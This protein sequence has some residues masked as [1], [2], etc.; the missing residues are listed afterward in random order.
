MKHIFTFHSPITYLVSLLTVKEERI[1]AEDAVFLGKNFNAGD[2]PYLYHPSFDG[3]KRSAMEKLKKPNEPAAFDKYISSIVGDEEYIAYVP[4]MDMYQRLLITHEKCVGFNFIE[5][6]MI[7][8]RL[9]TK[10]NHLYRNFKFSLRNNPKNNLREFMVSLNYILRGWTLRILEMPFTYEAYIHITGVHF[11]GISKEVF[12]LAPEER[13]T[14]LSINDTGQFAYLTKGIRLN[15]DSIVWLED[16]YARNNK[17]PNEVYLNAVDKAVTKIQEMYPG[18]KIYLKLRPNGKLSDST[19]TKVLKSR[20]IDF[21]LLDSTVVLEV[22]MAVNE[23]LIWV[24]N[25][26]SAL[27]YA[28]KMGHTSWSLYDYFTTHSNRTF[29]NFPIY[30]ENVNKL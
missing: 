7:S 29:D 21:E 3:L 2:V 6:G 11:Y 17:I 30:W 16:S 13:K 28:S 23:P 5:E 25:V 1:P 14:I 24:G 20:S 12:P 8:Y 9:S 10:L 15:R 4:L 26:S 19:V 27:F 18:Y 22:L